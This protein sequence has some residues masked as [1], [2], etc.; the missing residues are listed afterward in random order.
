MNTLENF[1]KQ[2]EE[3]IKRITEQ[4]NFSEQMIEK[5]SKDIKEFKLVIRYCNEDLEKLNSLEFE[6][7]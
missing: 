1:Q 3:K 7:K 2:K 5:L 6:N 4:I